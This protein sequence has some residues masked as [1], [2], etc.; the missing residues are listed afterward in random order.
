MQV[1]NSNISKESSTTG[2]NGQF[3]H[4]QLLIDVL[5]RLKSQSTDKSELI[6]FCE[7]KYKDNILELRVIDEFKENYSS[8]K[9]IWWYTRQSFLYRILNKALRTNN[10]DLLFLLRFFIQD[11][12]KYLRLN[13]YRRSIRVYR[14]Q[15]ISNDELDLLKNSIGQFISMNSFVS[16]SLNRQRALSFLEQS[17]DLKPILFIID[18]DP[19]LDEIK[20]FS[21]IADQSNFP[22]EDEFLFM[23]GSIFRIVQIDF[24]ENGL[25]VIRMNL[26]S[27]NQ[28]ELKSIFDY[29]K[30][31]YGDNQTNLLSFGK[32]LWTMGKYNQ[33]EKYFFRLLN[34][35]PKDDPLMSYCY[36]AL[37]NVADDRG[38]YETSLKWHFKAIDLLKNSNDPILAESYNSIGC[39][40]DTKGD[41]TQAIEF[42][43][44]ALE[45]WKE[46][47]GDEH[48]NIATSLN[49]IACVYA[50]R[51]EYSKALKSY[52]KVLEI[53]KKHLPSNHSDIGASY[54]NIGEIYRRLGRYESALEHLN[55]AHKIYHL[56]LPLDHPDRAEALMNIGLV[57]QNQNDRQQALFYYSEASK[58]YLQTLESTHSSVRKIDR[59]IKDLQLC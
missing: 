5:L 18:A 19:S 2:L 8:K 6:S 4:F 45:I 50:E 31:Q 12:E 41:Y 37:G 20:P 52:Q 9:A 47:Y 24:E 29:M 40:Y 44:K 48:L 30:K 1:F 28:T 25:W 7:E 54:N 36:R 21:H 23:L 43:K 10:I 53:R 27:K 58:I 59:L 38:D 33:A 26:C 46:I 3:L 34:E 13:Q 15:L 22:E 39:V 49:N 11:L 55:I 17:D 35:L 16:T 32:V 51:N 56:S 42:Y 57:Y 14:S